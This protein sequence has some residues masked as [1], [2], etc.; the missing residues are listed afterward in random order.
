QAAQV[1]DRSARCGRGLSDRVGFLPDRGREFRQ[2]TA[3]H[4]HTT[5]DHP[6][7]VRALFPNL[8]HRAMIRVPRK[9]ATHSLASFS[10]ILRWD[11]LPKI[12]SEV[13]VIRST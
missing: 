1:A 2:Q 4:H 12:V 3:L 11:R 7:L 9:N 10:A 13:R 8:F 6:E 5:R